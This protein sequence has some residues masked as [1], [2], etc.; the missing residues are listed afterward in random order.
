MSRLTLRLPETLHRQLETQAKRE[1]VSL[2]QLLV[3]VLTQH[4][5][6]SYSVQVLPEESVVQQQ[7][8]FEALRREL[9][10]V[11]PEV[12]STT[13]AE[14]DQVEPEPELQA[15]VVTRLQARLSTTARDETHSD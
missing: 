14:R 10:Q 12:L 3:Y 8:E 11:S 4:L 5:A 6:Q 9:R 7:T 1:G 15:D 13:L 2:N